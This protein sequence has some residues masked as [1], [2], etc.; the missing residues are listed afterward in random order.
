MF[1]VYGK[2]EM[3][4]MLISPFND[5]KDIIGNANHWN[6]EPRISN[7]TL[8]VKNLLKTDTSSF[9]LFNS[10]HNHLRINH[11]RCDN[12][13]TQFTSP[14]FALPCNQQLARLKARIQN[15]LIIFME[16]YIKGYPPSPLSHIL[17]SNKLACDSRH[18]EGKS[19]LG[20]SG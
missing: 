15:K 18:F 10:L 5:D 20:I 13:W 2:S 14:S 4:G 9:T 3:C 19:R 12:F 1:R 7:H 6:L 11:T 17:K 16:F 8:I